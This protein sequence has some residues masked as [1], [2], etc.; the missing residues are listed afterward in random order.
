VLDR[1][2]RSLKRWRRLTAGPVTLHFGFRRSVT[3]RRSKHHHLTPASP[4]LRHTRK[5]DSDAVPP[6]GGL[7]CGVAVIVGVGPGLGRA[8]ALRLA[9]SGMTLVVVSRNAGNQDTLVTEI[10]RLGGRAYAYA[11][12]ATD[13]GSIEALLEKVRETLDVPALVVYSLQW[14]AKTPS[15]DV[16][17]AELED[18]WRH[19]CLGPFLLAREAGRAMAPLGRGTIVLIGSTSSIVG[20]AEHLSFAVGKFGMRALAHVLA[21]ELW[22]KGIHV[23]HLLI[24]ADIREG[25]PED[26]PQSDPAHVAESIEFLHRQPRTAWTSEMDLRPWDEQFWQHC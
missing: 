19:N 26:Y 2:W 14:F 8:L 20:R 10:R 11:C 15:L 25:V 6:Q 17:V 16:S 9:A 12:D 4:S 24:D 22:P 3:I 21:R 23:A 1:L 7:L 18:S 13:E 5:V